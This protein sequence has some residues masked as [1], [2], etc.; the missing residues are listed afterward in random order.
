MTM[1]KKVKAV[2]FDFDGTLISSEVIQLKALER[3]IKEV[4][5]N[6]EV[7]FTFAIG[8]SDEFLFE[9]LKK[10]YNVPDNFLDINKKYF[11]IIAEKEIT[12]YNG[13]M[14]TLQ[15]LKNNNIKMAVAS[16]S[17][18][19]HISKMS[20]IT[21]VDKYIK[22][23]SSF[24]RLIKAKP[25]PDIFLRA[26]EKLDVEK[27]ECIIVED[28]IAGLKGAIASGIEAIAVTNTFPHDELKKET[29]IVI[30]NIKEIFDYI[31]I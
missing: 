15:I 6:E 30:D 25:A 9:G 31:E 3:A 4:G 16:N 5:I 7:D 13:V 26:F 19:E 21:G 2:I 28:S 23:Y 24:D 14:D 1:K 18:M 12:T 22:H 10:K 20:K 27:S 8:H 17:D 29:K 11:N